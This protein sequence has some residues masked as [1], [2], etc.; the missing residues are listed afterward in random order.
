MDEKEVQD[1]KASVE[2]LRIQLRNST[3]PWRHARWESIT[4]DPQAAF[5]MFL[6]G[7]LVWG[8][9]GGWALKLIGF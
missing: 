5:V 6:A 1:L 9:A 3:Q 8:L 2:A 7:A 4:K